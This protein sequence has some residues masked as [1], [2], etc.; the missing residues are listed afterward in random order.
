MAF[1]RKIIELFTLC[2]SEIALL[3]VF[4]P[5]KKVFCFGHPCFEMVI[6]MFQI[7]PSHNQLIMGFDTQHCMSRLT[8]M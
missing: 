1:F 6:D 3:I 2:G 4:T 8:V 5:S 7:R